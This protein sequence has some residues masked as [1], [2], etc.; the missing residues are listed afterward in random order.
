MEPSTLAVTRQAEILAITLSRA[1]RL[2]AINAAM[3][4]D[5]AA[6]LDRAARDPE[7]RVLTI[8]GAGRAFCA[9]GDLG[10]LPLGSPADTYHRVS[11]LMATVMRQIRSLPIPVLVGLNGVA[12]GGGA[13]LALAG[14][15]VIAGQGARLVLPWV[16]MGLTPDWGITRFL[17]EIVGPSRAKQ[18]LWT[19]ATIDAEGMRTLGIASEL[20]PD[21]DLAPTLAER[22]EELATAPRLPVWLT[23]RLIDDRS[24]D[25]A[26]VL[27]AEA[28]AQAVAT[29]VLSPESADRRLGESRP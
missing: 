11:G 14:D 5:L 9:G 7:L 28:R 29:A 26:S 10:E 27:E 12:A 22:A 18:L 23:K 8:T 1:E 2:N 20:V 25:L 24:G 19:S 13:S 15:I 16:R 21:E 4:V 17:P 3:L 6:V